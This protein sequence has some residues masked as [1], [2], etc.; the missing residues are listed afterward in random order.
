VHNFIDGALIAGSFL[1]SVPVGIATTVAV[2]LHEIPQEIGD[3]AILLYSGYTKKRALLLNFL[4][5]L[6]AL[7]GAAIVILSSNSLPLIGSYLLPLAAGNFVYIAGADLIPELHKETRLKQAAIQLLCM[8]AG[9][10]VMY[11]LTLV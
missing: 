9:I 6:A 8:I 7:L 1:V 5:A 10:L 3:F 2:A 4:T 11:G